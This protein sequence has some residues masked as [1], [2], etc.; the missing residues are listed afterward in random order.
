[1][2]SWMEVVF[3]GLSG[4]ILL[5]PVCDPEGLEGQVCLVRTEPS[6]DWFFPQ[7]C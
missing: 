7:R 3:F 1:M 2:V 4:V 5:D 6:N